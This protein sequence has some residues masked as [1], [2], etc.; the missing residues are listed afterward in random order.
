MERKSQKLWN[1]G[2]DA[3]FEA[4]WLMDD[5]TMAKVDIRRNSYDFQSHGTLSFFDHIHKK[6]N[7]VASIPWPQLNCLKHSHIE[8]ANEATFRRDE[9][10]LLK[11]ACELLEVQ[12]A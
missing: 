11:E 5:G 6:W 1:T 9:T 4:L 3:C 7:R 8:P 10:T 12:N 2:H